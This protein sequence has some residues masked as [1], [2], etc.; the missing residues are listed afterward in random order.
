MYN[1]PMGNEKYIYNFK[2]K[3]LQEDQLG[4]LGYY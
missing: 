1:T 3:H 4:D 2:Q